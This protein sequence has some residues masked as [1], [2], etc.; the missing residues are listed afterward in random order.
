MV[1]TCKIT[2]RQQYSFVGNKQVMLNIRCL[3]QKYQQGKITLQVSAL[4][5][6]YLVTVP[7]ETWLA[8]NVLY[9]WL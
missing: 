3:D 2:Q 4:M 7:F 6:K 9:F 8:I 1:G 5:I